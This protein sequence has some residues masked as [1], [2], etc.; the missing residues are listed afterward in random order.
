[1]IQSGVLCA[2]P[3]MD[4]R[5]AEIRLKKGFRMDAGDLPAESPFLTKV[6]Q[7]TIKKGSRSS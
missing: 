3:P 7:N 2:F 6:L 5:A 1:M 4:F